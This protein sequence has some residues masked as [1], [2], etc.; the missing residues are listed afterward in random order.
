MK[1][2]NRKK[3]VKLAYSYARAISRWVKAGRPTR[4]ENEVLDIFTAWCHQCEQMDHDD[5][6][7]KVCGCHVGTIKSPLLNKIAMGTE[8][9]PE[10][11]W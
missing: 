3:Y 1:T 2:T 10:N 5:S 9:C 11:K 6:R 8:H 4:N 7:C